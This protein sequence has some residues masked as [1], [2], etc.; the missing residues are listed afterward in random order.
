MY[1]SLKN[2][3]TLF[4]SAMLCACTTAPLASLNTIPE[5]SKTQSSI[6]LPSPAGQIL[7]PSP[8]G[9]ISSSPKASLTRINVDSVPSFA[10]KPAEGSVSVNGQLRIPANLVLSPNE[11]SALDSPQANISAPPQGIT[12]PPRGIVAP[13]SGILPAQAIFGIKALKTNV[14][15]TGMWTEFFRDNFK[16]SIAGKPEN[17]VFINQSVIQFINGTPYLV[18]NYIVPDLTPDQSFQMEAHHPFMTMY[19]SFSTGDKGQTLAADIDLGTTVLDLIRA[20][21]KTINKSLDFSHIKDHMEEVETIAQAIHQTFKG[22]LSQADLDQQVADFVAQLP[23]AAT[24]L[25]LS[26][27]GE[28]QTLTIKVGESVQLKPLTLF[29]NQKTS[30]SAFYKT[31]DGSLV[32]LSA[33]GQL[34][35]LKTGT[36]IIEASAIDDHRISDTLTVHIVSP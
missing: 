19:S 6:L 11:L 5:V 17:Q 1:K 21:A 34:M 32:H 24:P 28:T 18:A 9:H 30:N 14:Q 25:S 8:A 27:N 13:P 7:L 23:E 16:L 26:L 36:T 12:A 2:Y 3:S 35:G 15:A 33:E 4:V 10:V 22:L 31:G 20:R 29:N